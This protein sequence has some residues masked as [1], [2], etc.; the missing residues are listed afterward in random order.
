M[1]CYFFSSEEDIRA[2]KGQRRLRESYNSR[3]IVVYFGHLIMEKASFRIRSWQWS[4]TKRITPFVLLNLKQ[5]TL[6]VNISLTLLNVVTRQS[7]FM[8]KYF[9]HLNSS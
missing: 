6:R 3:K 9:N 4:E 8:I 1:C 7:I 5:L 2:I